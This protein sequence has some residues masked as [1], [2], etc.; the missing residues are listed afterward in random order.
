MLRLLRKWHRWVS[1][2]IAI[3]F[4]ITVVTGI[5][6]ASRGFNTWVQPQYPPVDSSLK[7]NFDEILAAA[8]S[9][10]EA[11]ISD[12]KD[13]SQ[14]DIRPG[15]GNIRVRSKNMLEIQIDGA[16]GKI[17]GAKTR[18]VSW[19]VSLHEGAEFGPWIRYGIFFPSAICVF[20]LLLSGVAVFFQ[21]LIARR[22]AQHK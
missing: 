16:N 20:F 19:L 3:P 8:K 2:V 7:I 1:I 12:W 15:T 17:M 18:R 13:I 4:L 14:I 11:Q 5:L 9:V 10:P 21:P 6:L 22:K